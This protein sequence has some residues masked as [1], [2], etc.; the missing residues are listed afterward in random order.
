MKK[1]RKI[2][3]GMIMFFGM[4]SVSERSLEKLPGVPEHLKSHI[5]FDSYQ[6]GKCVSLIG[7]VKEIVIFVD[8][9]E[10]NWTE[11]E[12]E[13]VKRVHEK[14]NEKILVEAENYNVPLQ[15]SAEYFHTNVEQTF[16]RQEHADW[17]YEILQNVVAQN[18]CLKNVKLNRTTYRIEMPEG[19]DFETAYKVN[20]VPIIIYKKGY[21]R[22]FAIQSSSE[23][24][25]EYTVLFH[26]GAAF[27]HEL[28]HLF[29]A[30]DLYV[31]DEIKLVAGQYF[32]DSIMYT[33]N[34]V[35][36]SLTA[37][38][39]GWTPSLSQEAVTFLERTI[40]ITKQE[41]NNAKENE[42]YT[43]QGVRYYNNGIYTGELMRGVAQGYGKMVWDDG[44]VYE[45]EWM[46]NKRHGTGTLVFA[47]GDVYTGEW[48]EGKKQGYGKYTWKSGS[49]YE[50][51][52]LD[53]M[54]HGH[55][56]YHCSKCGETYEA[57]WEYDERISEKV[58]II[59]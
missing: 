48:D 5:F 36:D 47:S 1:S 38:L 13:S 42:S 30:E 51:E 11:K 52:W 12:M 59:E 10:G 40:D 41:Y 2:L 24:G 17:V 31:H 29:G 9:D 45:G 58:P 32:S 46:Y 26:Q 19:Y 34:G 28:F 15:L 20:E 27:R 54:Q 50:G 16:D 3:I 56:I 39:L 6:N 21:G 7:D 37:Y 22:A 57:E 4:M 25:V 44:D 18:E 55:G 53:D 49:W 14:E 23:I 35:V 43:G 8:S 33:S